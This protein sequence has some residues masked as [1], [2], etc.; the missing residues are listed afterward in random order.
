MSQIGSVLSMASALAAHAG[1]RQELAA[2]NVAH[3]DTPGYRARDL[4]EF[5]ESYDPQSGLSVRMTRAGH[6][7]GMSGTGV[8]ELRIDPAPSAP[9]GNAVSLEA[10][11]RRAADIK[12]Q[13][14][15]ALSV[16]QSALGI[17]RTALARGA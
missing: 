11:M 2:R 5:A 9:N 13:H 3:A 17:L 12:H 16:Y 14:D 10:E 15:M 6:R 1:Q 4:A 8:A 7:D